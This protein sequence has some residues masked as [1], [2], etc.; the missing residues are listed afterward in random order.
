MSQDRPPKSVPNRGVAAILTLWYVVFSTNVLWLGLESFAPPP[1]PVA[2]EK[3]A[4]AADSCCCPKEVRDAHGCCCEAKQKKEAAHPA[5]SWI[6]V[7]RCATDPTGG[8]ASEA[9]RSIPHLPADEFA[10]LS[11]GG[12]AMPMSASPGSP[13]AGFPSFPDKVPL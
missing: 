11:R 12:L 4:T 8:A 10:P 6:Q 5:S 1:K 3:C 13:S 7:G 9:P 2:A